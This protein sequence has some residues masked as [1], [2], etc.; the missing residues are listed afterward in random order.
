MKSTSDKANKIKIIY[1]LFHLHFNKRKNITGRLIC[2][3]ELESQERLINVEYINSSWWR[4]TDISSLNE[5][6]YM[7]REFFISLLEIKVLRECMKQISIAYQSLDQR[8][9]W[10]DFESVII[11]F[12]RLANKQ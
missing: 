4:N 9:Y 3:K 2:S 10:T 12:D 1:N 7:N 11:L 8:R 5:V 6:E